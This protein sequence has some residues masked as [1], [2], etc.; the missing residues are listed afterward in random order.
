MQWA[1]AT[2]IRFVTSIWQ[3]DQECTGLHAVPWEDGL[4]AISRRLFLPGELAEA[5]RREVDPPIQV[6]MAT[7]STAGRLDWWVKERQHWWGRVRGANG[8]NGG[9]KLL[10]LVPR[11][12][13]SDDL[14]RL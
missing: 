9:S 11:A 6:D 1:S 2:L 8:V 4:P 13:H 12:A 3:D 5:D 10:I 14:T 7:W